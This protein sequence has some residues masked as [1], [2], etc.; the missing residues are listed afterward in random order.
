MY[1]RLRHGASAHETWA[2]VEKCEIQNLLEST[3]AHFLKAEFLSVRSLQGPVVHNPLHDMIMQLLLETP[4]VPSYS[5]SSERQALLLRYGT[6][7]MHHII[8][9][10]FVCTYI[11]TYIHATLQSVV[12]LM[13]SRRKD[14]RR[15][16]PFSFL[17]RMHNSY[18]GTTYNAYPNIMYACTLHIHNAYITEWL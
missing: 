3:K 16:F 13:E 14:L 4:I 15:K 2:Y 11:H 12:I 18:V 6:T 17:S 5:N 7:A 9:H 8:M 1:V 10:R